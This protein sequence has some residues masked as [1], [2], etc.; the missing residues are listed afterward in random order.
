M[1]YR[2][3]IMAIDQPTLETKRFVVVKPKDFKFIP[4]RS[5]NVSIP[6]PGLES[7]KRALPVTSLNSDYYF[8]FTFKEY[9]RRDRFNEALGNL[10]AGEEIIVSEMAGTLEYKGPGVFIA[11]GMGILP[12]L[13]ILRELKQ[14]S[15]LAGNI[16]LYSSKARSEL[17]MERE[18]KHMFGGK[19]I[20]FFLTWD[21]AAGYDNRRMDAEIL[22]E[23]I[24]NFD[25]EFYLAGSEN[26]VLEMK[27]ALESLGAK[28]INVELVEQ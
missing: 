19:N 14:E 26:F 4:G 18:L 15:A 12:F 6:K 24:S 10:K 7:Y 20:S 27:G 5:L 11:S 16:L 1:E 22:K 17:I 9:P 21:K 13:S 25:Q 8:E 28:S 23:K 2:L 3:K